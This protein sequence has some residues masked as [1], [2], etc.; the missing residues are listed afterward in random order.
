MTFRLKEKAAVQPEHRPDL[1]IGTDDVV[2]KGNRVT[3]T[4]HSLGSVAAP[5]GTVTLETPEGRA[6]ATAAVPALEAPTDLAP[7]TARIALAV[8]AGAPETLHVRVTSG[9]AEVTRR[10]DVVVLG[11]ENH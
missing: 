5:A 2:R 4:V 1:G 11:R 8:P 3:V 10:N 7:K 9:V 6:L